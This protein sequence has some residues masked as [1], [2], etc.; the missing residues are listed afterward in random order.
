MWQM[1]GA[2]ARSEFARPALEGGVRSRAMTGGRDPTDTA[3]THDATLVDP[4]PGGAEPSLGSGSSVAIRDF[5]S[6][7]ERRTSIDLHLR[8]QLW[9]LSSVTLVL[10]VASVAS[11]ALLGGSALVGRL[12][13]GGM[14]LNIGTGLWMGWMARTQRMTVKNTTLA[15]FI[16]TTTGG[17]TAILYF[18]PLSPP[19][20]MTAVFI[21]FF[22]GT[23]DERRVVTMVYLLF[24]V[25]HAALV[26]A[27]IGGV[28][29]D[30]GAITVARAGTLELLVVEGLIQLL[31][32]VT[33]VAACAIRAGMV[34]T[35]RDLEKRARIIGHHE[36][37]LEDAKRAFE[38]SL[39]AA[40]G[41]R[42]S[43]QNVGSY[44]LGRLLGEGAMGEVYDAVDTR[45][46]APAAVKLLRRAAMEDRWIVQ[47]F[48]TE[49]RVVTALHT[50]HIARVLETADPGSGLPY[51]AME[52]LH[53]HDLRK[54]LRERPGARLSLTEADDLLRQIA[55]GIDVAHRADVVHR[56]LKPSNLFR[57][58]DGTWK[59]LDFGVSKVIGEHTAA[60]AIVG[61]PN[62]MAPEQVKSRKVDRRTDIFALGAILY[63]AITGKLAFAGKNLAT[64]AYQVT[65]YQPPRPS[66]LVPGISTDVDDVV[67][68]A[69]AKDPRKRF[70]AATDLA[71]AFSRAVAESSSEIAARSS[72][73]APD[74]L[75]DG[76]IPRG[77]PRPAGEA[78]SVPTP[79]DSLRSSI[80]PSPEART[81]RMPMQ[82]A[83]HRGNNRLRPRTPGDKPTE[84]PTPEPG[85]DANR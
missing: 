43:H 21:T 61:T 82:R 83:R 5:E 16:I 14:L 51:I 56:D 37:V 49:A 44:R 22:V 75:A 55:R 38:A 52:R 46:G 74:A 2:S 58:D 70:Q 30:P 32:L 28:L 29:D 9:W 48:L 65:H 33:V 3:A 23:R 80:R 36:L 4:A 41:G 24:A 45:T 19:G 34:S 1:R 64:V 27:M 25:F 69:L 84:R 17:W 13:L 6:E 11:I 77:G 42:F 50:D 8:R 31:L 79:D 66:E 10:C 85:G 7:V 26:G 60:N 57:I 81:V 59:I 47:R 62:F 20:M 35:V 63:Y 54:H 78:V 71:D 40:G 68:T 67:M 76:S 18:G 15:W 39:R 53:G 72:K 73:I 12:F